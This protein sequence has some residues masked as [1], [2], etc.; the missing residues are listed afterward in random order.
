MGTATDE[1]QGAGHTGP[2]LWAPHGSV[3]IVTAS[4]PTPHEDPK[5]RGTSPTALPTE[6]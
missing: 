3:S 5:S 1:P 2:E 4:S 6:L